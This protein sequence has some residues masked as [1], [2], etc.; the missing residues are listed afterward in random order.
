LYFFGI[1]I[2]PLNFTSPDVINNAVFTVESD[3]M[4]IVRDID[5]FSMCEHHLVPFFGKLHIGLYLT[6]SPQFHIISSCLFFFV[7]RATL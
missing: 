3:D 7:C 4:V 6:H 5:V 1:L 2:F